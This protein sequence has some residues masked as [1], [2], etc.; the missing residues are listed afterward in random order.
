M[1][2]PEPIS[3]TSLAPT[4]RPIDV[5]LKPLMTFAK[6]KL[7]GAGL[8]LFATVFALGWASSPWHDT[9][10]HLL[11]TELAVKLAISGSA[12]R[13]STGSTTA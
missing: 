11:E 13:W 5:L 12:T 10:H 8:L 3:S 9:L 7:A 4:E 2:E 6:H 1:H